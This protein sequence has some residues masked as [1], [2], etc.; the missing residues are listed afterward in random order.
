MNPWINVV[1]NPLGLGGFA[2]FLVFSFVGSKKKKPDWLP[3]GAYVMAVVAL[4]GGIFIAYRQENQ[5]TAANERRLMG[6]LRMN[7]SIPLQQFGFV[8][9][10]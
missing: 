8:S 2:L 3:I 4:V 7:Q 9:G 6:K 5:S 10:Q 1:T